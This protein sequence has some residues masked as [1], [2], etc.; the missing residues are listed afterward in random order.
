M[1]IYPS[2]GC[3]DTQASM[4]V[5]TPTRRLSPGGHDTLSVVTSRG[6]DRRTIRVEPELWN[7]FGAATVDDEDGRSGILR[8]FMRWYLGKPDAELPQPK[9][10]KA[11]EA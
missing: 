7:E 11:D 6:T 10:G 3:H 5:M 1:V 9:G 4:G 2:S 8:Q